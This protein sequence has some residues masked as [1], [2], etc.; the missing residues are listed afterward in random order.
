MDK[1]MKDNDINDKKLELD[2]IITLNNDLHR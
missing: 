1:D 2:E